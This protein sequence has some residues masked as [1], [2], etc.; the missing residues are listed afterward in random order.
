MVNMAALKV[1]FTLH[2][3]TFR[4]RLLWPILTSK[5]PGSNQFPAT[6]NAKREEYVSRHFSCPS[7][8]IVAAQ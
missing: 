2:I 4:C 1:Y 3:A 5:I 8:T 7:I 6:Q